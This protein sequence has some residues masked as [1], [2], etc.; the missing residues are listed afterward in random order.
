MSQILIIE[1]D[2]L[3]R[4]LLKKMLQNQG[5]E[6]IEAGSGEEGLAKLY[7]FYPTLILCDWELPGVSGLTICQKVKADPKLSLIYFILLTAHN[8]PEYHIQGLDSGAD[9]F[10]TKPIQMAELSA[11]VRAGLRLHQSLQEQYRLTQVLQAEMAEAADYVRS[12]MPP[13]MSGTVNI[14]SQFLPSQQLGG[15]CFDYRWLDD[16]WLAIYLL[17]VSG[18]GLGSALLSVSVQNIL[19]TQVLPDVNFYQPGLVLTALNEAFATETSERYFTIWYGVYD[20]QRRLLFYASAGHPP[21][22]LLSGDAT[23]PQVQHLRTPATPIGMFPEIRYT[24]QFCKVEPDSTLYLFSDGIYE[25]QQPDQTIWRLE[26]WIV[27]LRTHHH[28]QTQL[29][30]Q[31]LVE[32]VQAAHQGQEFK[33]DCSLLQIKFN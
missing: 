9:D 19:R 20:R 22:I 29:S 14:Q 24:S 4:K 23:N 8:T 17:D 15:D 12:L 1:D 27:F 25:L 5:Y 7:L 13:P 31:Q 30:P 6:V 33:D 18:H 2:V 28:A 3:I 32:Q 21:A 26:D 11:R 10:L 16:D